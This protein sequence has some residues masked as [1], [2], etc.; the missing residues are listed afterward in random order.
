M[1][2]LRSMVALDFLT[3]DAEPIGKTFIDAHNGFNK[4]RHL[5]IL[6]TVRHFWP[7]GGKVCVQFL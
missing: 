5:A 7:E 4:L 6:W 3:Q 2:T 1:G